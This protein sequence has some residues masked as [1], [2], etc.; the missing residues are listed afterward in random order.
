MAVVN[1]EFSLCRGRMVI[2]CPNIISTYNK[3]DYV[4]YC[5]F[6]LWM[7]SCVCDDLRNA[8]LFDGY[9]NVGFGRCIV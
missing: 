2:L 8:V 7:V 4:G 6:F 3:A 5:G 9:L 1:V